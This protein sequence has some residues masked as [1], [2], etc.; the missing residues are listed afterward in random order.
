MNA[1]WYAL[2]V[3]TGSELMISNNIMKMAQV[4]GISDQVIDTF[5][6]VRKVIQLKKQGRKFS[7]E[8]L[9]PGYIFVRVIEFSPHIWHFFKEIFGVIRVLEETP[10]A[11]HEI[12]HLYSQSSG[13]LEVQMEQQEG[14][15]VDVESDLSSL[16]TSQASFSSVGGQEEENDSYTS[17]NHNDMLST[18]VEEVTVGLQEAKAKKLV[19]SIQKLGKTFIRVPLAIYRYVLQKNEAIM[20][21]ER[22]LPLFVKQLLEFL[23]RHHHELEY[24]STLYVQP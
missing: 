15:A 24:R 5:A 1:Q 12:E 14:V 16:N 7:A 8:T 21:T 11:E 2:Q 3:S 4:K 19:R 23:G 18:A 6:C 20:V 22:Q 13:E 17:L 10:I 9:L